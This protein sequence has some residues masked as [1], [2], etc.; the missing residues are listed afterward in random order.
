VNNDVAR[1]HDVLLVRGTER[2]ICLLTYASRPD[3]RYELS[4]EAPHGLVRVVGSDLFYALQLVREQLE[5]SG[6]QIAVQGGRRCAWASGM[7]R[8]MSGGISVYI[9]ELGREVVPREAVGL[10]D[11]ADVADIVTVHE[12][13]AFH[14]EWIASRRP[15]SDGLA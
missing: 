5:P 6:W 13:T 10:F 9:C 11:P 1:S 14:Q 12:Q 15:K 4:V 3:R 7:Q 2:H 8:D